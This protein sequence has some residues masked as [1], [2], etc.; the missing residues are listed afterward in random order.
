M[1]DGLLSRGF[2]SKCKSLMKA[3][4]TRIEVVRKRAEVKQRFLKEDLAKLLSSGL[5]VNAFGRTEEFLA[6]LDLL[7]CYDF[8]EYACEY[9]VKH[10]S[11]MQKQREC[12]VEC[13]EPV[14]S[15][16]FAAARFSDLPELRDLR[17]L[18]RERYGSTLEYFVNQ[19]FIEKLSSTPPVMEKRLQLLKDIAS[20]FSI[21]WDS[22]GFEQKMAVQPTLT[23]VQPNIHAPSTVA[24]DKHNLL[25]GNGS[26]AKSDRNDVSLKETRGLR[27]GGYRMH[28]SSGGKHSKREDG[29]VAVAKYDRR[30]SPEG[31]SNGGHRMHNGRGAKESKTKDGGVAVLQYD[32]YDV[33]PEETR[34]LINGCHRMHNQR[35][36]KEAR[37]EDASGVVA[38]TDRYDVS[39][40][41]TH[42]LNNDGLRMHNGRESKDSRREELDLHSR[43]R[44]GSCTNGHISPMKKGDSTSRLVKHDLLFEERQEVMV[45]KH[46]LSCKKDGKLFKA[47]KPGTSSLR[48]VLENVGSGYSD[49]D[50]G[51][52]NMLELK[53]WE[54]LSHGKTKMSPS[55]GGFPGKNEGVLSANEHVREKDLGNSDRIVQQEDLDSLK[56]YQNVLLPPPYIKSKNNAVLPPYVKPKHK[57]SRKS[58]Q[59]GPCCDGH[60]TDTSSHNRVNKENGLNRIQREPDNPGH[61]GQN[62]GP[63]RVRSHRHQKDEYYQNDKIPLPKPRSARGKQHKSSSNHEDMSH[64]DDAGSVKRSASSRRRDYSLKGLQLLFDDEDSGKDE[65]ERM[66][67]KLL[68]HYSNKPSTYDGGKMRKVSQAHPSHQISND[69]HDGHGLSPDIISTTMRS[70][71]LPRG[72]TKPSE[73]KKVFTRVNSYQPDGQARHVHPKLPDYDDLAAR[74]ASLKGR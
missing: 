52:T 55:C 58:E 69:T 16:M 46:K 40:K 9:V 2:S 28:S 72:E 25:N 27:N 10:L 62:V 22:W 4:R 64:V 8:I 13:R 70:M 60:S 42:G 18:F 38:K 49:Q 7:A 63:G 35:E 53:S 45:D 6:G 44:Q 56:S 48:K 12:P 1:L 29:S 33:S 37:R 20:E 11:S 30:V 43:R 39:L 57:P 14:A 66:I 65:E 31:L 24:A 47:V 15:L 61:E 34:G 3:T 50:D 68:L 36:D 54:D 26:F 41:E 21:N 73:A 5:D 19:K 32:R 17:D 23:Q 71:S 74:F 59:A 67:D 51:S